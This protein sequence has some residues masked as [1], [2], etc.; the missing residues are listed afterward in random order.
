M[1]WIVDFFFFFGLCS[2][3]CVDVLI[4]GCYVGHFFLFLLVVLF[5]VFL[6]LWEGVLFVSS[7]FCLIYFLLYL[8]LATRLIIF[9]FFNLVISVFFWVSLIRVLLVMELIFVV[10]FYRCFV[11]WIWIC[12]TMFGDSVFT[13]CNCA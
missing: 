4:K 5:P 8:V 7:V 11:P 3:S 10:W 12:L 2:A 6:W 13:F 1:W 9:L